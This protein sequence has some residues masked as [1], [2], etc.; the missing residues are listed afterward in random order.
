VRS[1]CSPLPEAPVLPLCAMLCAQHRNIAAMSV[2]S[3]PSAATVRGPA[4]LRG[5][6]RVVTPARRSVRV[7]AGKPTLIYFPIPGRAEVARL[8]FTIGGIEYEVSMMLCK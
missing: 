3:A 1:F 5:P 2:R 6:S 8:C 4:V 7:Y